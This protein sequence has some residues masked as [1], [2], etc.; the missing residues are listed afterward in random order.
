MQG[1]TPRDEFM[2]NCPNCGHSFG[3][4]NDF[5]LNDGT[6]LVADYNS[7]PTVVVNRPVVSSQLYDQPSPGKSGWTQFLTF[8]IILILAMAAV[9][10]GV[11]Y[12]MARENDTQGKQTNSNTEKITTTPTVNQTPFATPMQT[13]LRMTT[14][15]PSPVFDT[16]GSTEVYVP[17]PTTNVRSGPGTG[18]PVLCKITTKR[19]FFVQGSSGVADNNGI[20]YITNVC[21]GRGYIHSGQIRFE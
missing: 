17:R 7:Q 1:S 16:S 4:E 3:D 13:P 12:F 14:P 18:H 10:F 21:G 2:K 11:A 6:R 20:W 8:G 19:P 5:C 9:G 15:V